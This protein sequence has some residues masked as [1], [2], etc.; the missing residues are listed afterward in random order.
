[1]KDYMMGGPYGIHGKKDECIV[2]WC[3]NIKEGEITRKMEVW[4]VGQHYNFF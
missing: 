1:M 2:Y 4:L 3:E